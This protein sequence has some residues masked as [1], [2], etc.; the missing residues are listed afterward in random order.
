MRHTTVVLMILFCS[1]T[2]FSQENAQR[3]TSGGQQAKI[4]EFSVSHADPSAVAGVLTEQFDGISFSA[5]LAARQIYGRVPED[6]IESIV[7]FINRMDDGAERDRMRKRN[8]SQAEAENQPEI[9][10][11]DLEHIQP[12]DA[13]NVLSNLD[14]LGRELL[15][16]TSPDGRLILRGNTSLIDRCEAVLQRIDVENG[17]ASTHDAAVSNKSNQVKK[18]DPA[19]TGDRTPALQARID[20]FGAGGGRGMMGGGRVV[21]P[22]SAENVEKARELMD[23]ATWGQGA[24]SIDKL[25]RQ[26]EQ[27]E[28]EAAKIAKQ[29][30]VLEQLASQTNAPPNSVGFGRETVE[31][32]SERLRHVVTHAFKHRMLLQR[33]RLNQAEADLQEARRQLDT[34]QDDADEIIQR[35]VEELK[36]GK[37]TSWH[38]NADRTSIDAGAD[39]E[40]IEAPTQPTEVTVAD[41]ILSR[42]D[43]VAL[44]NLGGS[45]DF[46]QSGNAQVD[47]TCER[48]FQMRIQSAENAFKEDGQNSYRFNA[49]LNE[50]TK[51]LLS[52][53]RAVGG[54]SPMPELKIAMSIQFGNDPEARK[55][56][57]LNALK[58]DFNKEIYAFG[59]ATPVVTKVIALRRN[60]QGLEEYMHPAPFADQQVDALELAKKDNAIVLAKIT[61]TKVSQK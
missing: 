3:G 38:G 61:M 19:E 2:A 6:R 9:R 10:F 42:S 29:I 48:K 39:A 26:Y 1:A 16:S 53:F 52:D 28:R 50:E 54:L 15:S 33:E 21:L 14:L 24:D 60:R 13:L 7:S 49:P 20:G 27:A 57:R 51:L 59:D 46:E 17:E 41:G 45:D 18:A 31:T 4:H 22:G 44:A 40:S 34:R 25:E 32:L 12:N 55:Y 5:D 35:R 8:E 11:I 30:R 37:D 47:L 58:L 56:L 43:N 36:S 23:R